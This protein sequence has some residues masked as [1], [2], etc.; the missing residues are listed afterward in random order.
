MTLRV[1]NTLSGRVE[2]VVPLRPGKVGIYVCGVTVYDR[3][4]VGHA[5]ALVAFDVA[6][7]LPA[8][9]RLRRHLRPQLHR[10]RRQDHQARAA[11]RA[12]APLELAEA[13]HRARSPRTW[14]CSAACRPTIEPRATEHIAEMIALIEELEAQGPR[15]PG[16]TATST[17]PSTSFADYGKLSK[18]KLDDMM[19][20][21]RVEVDERKHDPMDF[22]LW[23]ASKPGEPCVG[24]PVGPGPAGLAHRVLGDGAASTS[25]SRSTSTAAATTSSSRTTRT[26][27]RS[28]RAPTGCRFA[29]YWMHNGMVTIGAEKMS[30]SL[31][32]FLTVARGGRARSAARRCACSSSARTTAAR[33]TSR[34]TAST[35][36]SARLDRLY[37]T[38]ARA[39]EALR[40]ARRDAR[41]GAAR[42]DP[43]RVP[44]RHGRRPQHR[45][46]PGARLRRGARAQPP[47]ST[48]ASGR[49]AAACARRHRGDGRRAR[50]RRPGSARLPGARQGARPRRQRRCRPAQIER[51][52]AERAAARKAQGLQARRRDPRRA[53][54]QGRRPRG[55]RPGHDL[56][57]GKELSAVAAPCSAGSSEGRVVTFLCRRT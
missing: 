14:R 35:R 43:R 7:P 50:R 33:S 9:P 29:R 16:A 13:R 42:R 23:K 49:Q 11:R 48:P 28:P 2:D 38:L 44:R 32:N 6:L 53:E 26:R 3:S 8:R 25:A 45:A 37:E 54:G 30:K 20:G 36:P 10:R 34:P 19:A 56:E 1:H 51:L 39:D 18:R 41:C 4:H 47:R 21:A 52:I 57:G 46:R 22:A 5:R 17:S 15:V 12:S 24:E 55:L 27:S 40:G 31:G